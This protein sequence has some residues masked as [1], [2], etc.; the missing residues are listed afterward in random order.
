[1]PRTKKK[2]GSN[3]NANEA[4]KKGKSKYKTLSTGQVTKKRESQSAKNWLNRKRMRGITDR[5]I[6]E[7]NSF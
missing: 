3:S 5:V 2:I 7:D 1:M 6:V 4:L